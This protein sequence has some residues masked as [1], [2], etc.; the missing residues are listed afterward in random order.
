MFRKKAF[1]K[2]IGKGGNINGNELSI[3]NQKLSIKLK[4]L[5]QLKLE[6]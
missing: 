1:L 3:V 2:I 5:F 6:C 4:K